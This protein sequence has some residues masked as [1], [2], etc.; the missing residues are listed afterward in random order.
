MRTHK[1][2][3]FFILSII[4]E[5]KEKLNDLLDARKH[6]LLITHTFIQPTYSAWD[7]VVEIYNI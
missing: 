5:S 7:D 2:T 4:S 3:F 1:M 6:F